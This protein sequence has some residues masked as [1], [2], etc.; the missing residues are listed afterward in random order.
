MYS[1]QALSQGFTGHSQPFVYTD[2]KSIT[3][4]TAFMD[5]DGNVQRLSD[6]RGKVVLVNLWATWCSACLYEMP[7]LNA[8]QQEWGSKGLKVLTLN[9]D[10]N[11]GKAALQ[12]LHSRGYSQLTGH[13]DPNY[14]FGQAFGQKLLPMTLLFDTTGRQ[15]GHLV[16]VAEWNSTKAKHLIG[17]YLPTDLQSQK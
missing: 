4:D 8:L 15:I 6:Y 12:F 13:L 2:N 17:K 16:G 9:Q 3:P 7:E 1:S 10:L 11:D 5:K 14:L